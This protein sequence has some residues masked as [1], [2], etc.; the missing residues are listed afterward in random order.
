MTKVQKFNSSSRILKILKTFHGLKGLE[1]VPG[2]KR[3]LEVH[4]GALESLEY[5]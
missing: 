1:P 3:S 5:Y 4:Y 2:G